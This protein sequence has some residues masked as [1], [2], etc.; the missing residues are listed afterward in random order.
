MSVVSGV[1]VCVCRCSCCVCGSVGVT[2]GRGVVLLC[3]A[4]RCAVFLSR[5]CLSGVFTSSWWSGVLVA[6]FVFNCGRWCVE[7]RG[8]LSRVQLL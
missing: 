8:L 5:V 6:C 2:R 7:L 3:R 1:C 4:G